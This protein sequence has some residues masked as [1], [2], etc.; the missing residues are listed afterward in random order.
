VAFIWITLGCVFGG[1]VHDYFSGMISIRNHGFSITEIV[2]MFLGKNIKTITIILTLVLM[3]MV[4]A[5]FI[6]G[7]AK[8]LENLTS[9]GISMNLW[10]VIII[11]YYLI[12]TLLPIHWQ[13]LPHLWLRT[14]LYGGWYWFYD[15]KK[16][17]K[18]P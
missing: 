16:R 1:A 6:T 2:G 12:A 3:V 5:V 4:G 17:L 8:L 10:M 7:P 13:N 11:L 14:A 15:G 18:H 9:G